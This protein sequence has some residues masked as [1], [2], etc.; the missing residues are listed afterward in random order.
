PAPLYNTRHSWSHGPGPARARGRARL[1]EKCTMSYAAPSAEPAKVPAAARTN[2]PGLFL[3]IVGAVNVAF[4]LYLMIHG[5][6]S[7][8]DEDRRTEYG[9]ALE[10]V[11]AESAK[12]KKDAGQAGAQ[13]FSVGRAT[14]TA[15]RAYYWSGAYGGALVLTLGAVAL[16]AGLLT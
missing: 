5:A 8:A 11:K 13:D 2:L 7:L 15:E 10:K 16:V 1:R 9:D 4:A 6:L 12:D 14:E 3:M